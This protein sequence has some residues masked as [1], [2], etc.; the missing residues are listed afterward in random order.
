MVLLHLR[1]PL[2]RFGGRAESGLLPNAGLRAGGRVRKPGKDFAPMKRPSDEAAALVPAA[3]FVGFVRDGDR[4][5]VRIEYAQPEGDISAI[6]FYD[7]ESVA[8]HIATLDREGRDTAEEHAALSAL[9][10]EA[11]KAK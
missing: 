4:V 7:I 9:I 8:A 2:P 10:T 3:H 11:G 6:V 1:H 5:G